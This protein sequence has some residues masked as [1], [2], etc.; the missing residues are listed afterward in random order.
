MYQA[1][2]LTTTQWDYKST[3]R[4][5]CKKPHKYVKAKQYATKQP[6]DH[7]SNQRGNKKC[8]KTNEDESMTIQNLWDAAKAILL[9]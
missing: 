1:S 7:W 3:V 6:M 8:L 9:L 5:N 4:R 2:F